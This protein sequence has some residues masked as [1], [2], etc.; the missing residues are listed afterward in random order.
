MPQL[1][2]FVLVLVAIGLAVTYW[3]VLLPVLALVVA[4]WWFVRRPAK[5]WALATANEAAQAVG[6]PAAGAPGYAV[7][8]FE[9]TG[10]SPA[11]NAR[12]VEMAVV[13]VDLTGAVTHRWSSLVDP[14]RKIRN[15]NIHGVTDADVAG[16]PTF[17]ELAPTL[18]HL[19]AGRVVVAHN[20]PFDIR[21]LTA[22]AAG[23]GLAASGEVPAVC[24]LAA[25]H[26]YQP[27]LG[28]RR[29]TDCVA[30]AGLPAFEAHGALADATAAAQLLGFYLRSGAARNR[31]FAQT[32]VQARKLTWTAEGPLVAGHPRGAALLPAQP[33]AP[34]GGLPRVELT[35]ADLATPLSEQAEAYLY[36]VDRALED[37][38]LDDA[39]RIEL[40]E[41]AAELGLNRAARDDAH[42]AYLQAVAAASTTDGED[43]ATRGQRLRQLAGQLAV[44]DA[45]LAG[46]AA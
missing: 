33:V 7:I 8:D 26:D 44:S 29:L 35:F 15:S 20:A 3:Y 41:V 12:I 21:F 42:R 16:A 17:A 24:T 34:A 43:A 13:H 22:E 4:W 32:L 2:A 28:R 9:T 37:G 31:R 25:S 38:Q 14:G 5:K 18:A 46:L 30:A 23:A 45:D 40:L 27:R 19:L 39:E 11:R 10:L 1:L 36:V 6:L